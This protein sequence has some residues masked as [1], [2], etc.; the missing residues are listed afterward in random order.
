MKEPIT[1]LILAWL[2]VI[3]TYTLG[4]GTILGSSVA[5]LGIGFSLVAYVKKKE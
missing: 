5:V 2:C 3:I 1:Y 4:V